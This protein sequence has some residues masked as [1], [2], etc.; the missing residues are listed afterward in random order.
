MIYALVKNGLVVNT[1][2]A[3]P[4]FISHIKDQYDHCIQVSDDPGNPSIGWSYDGSSFSPP[5]GDV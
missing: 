1:I 5:M 4:D 3:D 2:V